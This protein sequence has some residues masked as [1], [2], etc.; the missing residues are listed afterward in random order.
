[1][2]QDLT[3]DSVDDESVFVTAVLLTDS[4]VSSADLD[5]IFAALTAQFATQNITQACYLD[6]SDGFSTGDSAGDSAP[7]SSAPG[8]SQPP[9]P[10]S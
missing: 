8:S 4:H 10:S 2:L 6:Y 1:M 5:P 9:P 7:P 3:L